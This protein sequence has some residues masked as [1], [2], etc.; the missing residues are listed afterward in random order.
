[1]RY[2]NPLRNFLFPAVNIGISLSLLTLFFVIAKDVIHTLPWADRSSLN[3]INLKPNPMDY[4]WKLNFKQAP[5]DTNKIRLYVDYYEHYLEVSSSLDDIFGILGYCYCHLGK[6]EK[7]AEL[8]KEAIKRN[9]YYFWYYYNLAL[10]YITEH[11]YKEAETLLEQVS[12]FTS[13]GTLLTLRESKIYFAL[14]E[15]QED[16]LHVLSNH[17]EHGHKRSIS[18]MYVLH[19]AIQEGSEETIFKDFKPEFYAF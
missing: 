1:M 6:K 17:F 2:K 11:Q 19:Q 3:D 5:L 9:P 4:I 7:A 15:N 18:L 8:L 16:S 14:I 12:Q 10:L 13:T